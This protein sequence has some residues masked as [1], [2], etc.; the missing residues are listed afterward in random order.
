MSIIIDEELCNGCGS[1]VESCMY[2]AIE[3]ENNI[4]KVLEDNCILCK[5]CIEACPEEAISIEHNDVE[6]QK[7]DI[8]QF[9]GVWVVAEHYK[10]KIHNVA[11]QLLR[12]GREL[13]EA[14]E[15]KLTLVILGADFDDKLE[16]FTQYGMDEILYV[17][18]PIL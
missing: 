2:D 13:A 7:A 9:K 11:F 3:L 1:C 4:A 14:L 5:A 12:K 6:A 18:S 10:N 17:K 16:E 15:V 8:S